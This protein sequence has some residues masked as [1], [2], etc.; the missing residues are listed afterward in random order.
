[1][2]DFGDLHWTE[3]QSSSAK[4]AR[5]VQLRALG[6]LHHS[7]CKASRACQ[8]NSALLK[9]SVGAPPMLGVS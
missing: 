8:G 3:I 9:A 2:L 4:L 5:S 6:L 1:M 7:Q